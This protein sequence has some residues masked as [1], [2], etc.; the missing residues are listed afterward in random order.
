MGFPV[1]YSYINAKYIQQ[2]LKSKHQIYEFKETDKEL[3][4]VISMRAYKPTQE[5]I[6][7]RELWLGASHCQEGQEGKV[8]VM[9]QIRNVHHYQK[10]TLKELKQVFKR[11]F[12]TK[13]VLKSKQQQKTLKNMK[14]GDILL[15]SDCGCEINYSYKRCTKCCNKNKRKVERPNKE[16]LINEIEKYSQEW[17]AKKYGVTRSSIR[18]WIIS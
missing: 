13:H 2:L 6:D 15:Y 11:G 5:D 4:F 16:F 9:K 7:S 1:N 10:E 17:C 8:F 18:R 3:K 12:N 14:D